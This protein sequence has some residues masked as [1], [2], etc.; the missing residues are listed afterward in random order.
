MEKDITLSDKA[1]QALDRLKLLEGVN[2]G[3][4]CEAAPQG[5]AVE[6]TF[7]KAHLKE[8]IFDQP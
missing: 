4:P 1:I 5:V 3:K 8:T 6:T 7:F 2:A